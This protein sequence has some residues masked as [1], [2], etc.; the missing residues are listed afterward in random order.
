MFKTDSSKVNCFTI[1]KNNITKS[2]RRVQKNLNP[3]ISDKIKI[4]YLNF[5]PRVN[6]FKIDIFHEF[7]EK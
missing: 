2:N 1:T 7:T 4:Y 6:T 3:I 5:L